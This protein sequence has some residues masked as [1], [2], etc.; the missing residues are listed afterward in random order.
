MDLA[1]ASIISDLNADGV[2]DIVILISLTEGTSEL[3][4]F[5]RM[6]CLE[7]RTIHHLP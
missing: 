5:S 3:A 4:P 7:K 2:K 1:V 6:V